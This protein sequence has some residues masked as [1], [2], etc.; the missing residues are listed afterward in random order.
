MIFFLISFI[1]FLV[2]ALKFFLLLSVLLTSLFSYADKGRKTYRGLI[3]FDSCNSSDRSPVYRA[4]ELLSVELIHSFIK[5]VQ[6]KPEDRS[7]E[8]MTE[9]VSRIFV[10]EESIGWFE[11]PAIK[12]EY[13]SGMTIKSPYIAFRGY[14]SSSVRDRFVRGDLDKMGIKIL[15]SEI[16]ESKLNLHFG[17]S[18]VIDVYGEFKEEEFKKIQFTARYPVSLKCVG[19]AGIIIRFEEGSDS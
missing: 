16:V 17:Y 1:Y 9:V 3:H 6:N 8:G 19:V 13:E 12:K 10:D 11:M 2:N 15:K 7:E 18:R 14:V 5:G 4:Y